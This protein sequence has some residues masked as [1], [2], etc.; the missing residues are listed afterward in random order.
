MSE[1]EKITGKVPYV[2][3]IRTGADFPQLRSTK[4]WNDGTM[5]ITVNP[6]S[7]N[8]ESRILRIKD[9]FS[10][11]SEGSV[12]VEFWLSET[13]GIPKLLKVDLESN[14]LELVKE[15]LFVREVTEAS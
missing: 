9:E 7:K 6:G 5:M 12:R 11:N 4:K 10:L 1:L 14:K 15:A 13:V 2:F 8:T 3:I